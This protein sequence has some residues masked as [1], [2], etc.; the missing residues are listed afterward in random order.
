MVFTGVGV[1]VKRVFVC[2]ELQPILRTGTPRII[3]L[4]ADLTVFSVL[5]RDRR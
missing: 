5:G 3:N 1:E 2:P 4:S